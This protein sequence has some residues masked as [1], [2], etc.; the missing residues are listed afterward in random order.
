MPY[1]DKK[2]QIY[3]FYQLCLDPLS[4]KNA[5]TTP[6]QIVDLLKRLTVEYFIFYF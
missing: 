3:S 2:L 1:K 4:S 5:L 6:C